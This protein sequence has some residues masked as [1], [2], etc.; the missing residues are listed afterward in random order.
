MK[1]GLL[2]SFITFTITL[3]TSLITLFTQEGVSKFSDISETGYAAAFLGA[4]VA[5]AM[6]YKARMANAPEQPIPPPKRKQG[7]FVHVYQVVFNVI[8]GIGLIIVLLTSCATIKTTKD[9]FQDCSKIV[10]EQRQTGACFVLIEAM[11]E[12]VDEAQDN[13]L[14]TKDQEDKVLDELQFVKD[15]LD[16]YRNT[17]DQSQALV[18]V[19]ILKR[20]QTGVQSE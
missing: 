13:G 17:G 10:T 20:I 14:I 6:S 15:M 9:L 8:V 18:I 16:T 3:S 1:Q 4:L 7:G 19:N 2:S 11:A 5:A 12:S